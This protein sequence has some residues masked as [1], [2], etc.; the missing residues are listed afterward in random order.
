MYLLE[1]LFCF[2]RSCEYCILWSSFIE[3]LIS[4]QQVWFL[5]KMNLEYFL[6]VYCVLKL[7]ALLGQV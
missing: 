7:K 3:K 1:F 2:R 4:R 5:L 6:G